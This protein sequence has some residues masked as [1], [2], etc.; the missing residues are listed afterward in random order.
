M[1]AAKPNMV[2]LCDVKIVKKLC[3]IVDDTEHLK[4][5]GGFGG[6][7]RFR[8]SGKGD[9]GRGRGGGGRGGDRGTPFKAR[10]GGGNGGGRGGGRGGNRGGMKG[11]SKV[12]VQP[13][14]HDGFFIAKDKKDAIV[15]NLVLSEAVY[16]E[17]RITVQMYKWMTMK[18]LMLEDTRT[19]L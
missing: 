6:S 4:G 5:R 7:G 15:K 11:G 3:N 16:N 13:Y 17:K 12:M 2:N 19:L 10:G 8:G 1:D 14:R 18:N 9:R